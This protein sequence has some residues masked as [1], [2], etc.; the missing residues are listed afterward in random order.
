[1]VACSTLYFGDHVGLMNGLGILVVIIGSYR[2]GTTSIAEK[3]ET[4]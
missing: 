1:M 3:Q 2:Y 4:V